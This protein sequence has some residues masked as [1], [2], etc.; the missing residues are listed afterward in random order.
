MIFYFS[1]TYNFLPCVFS[2]LIF[3]V[4]ILSHVFGSSWGFFLLNEKEK[5]PKKKKKKLEKFMT[6]K[7]AVTL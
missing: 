6:V 3:E 2:S 1:L 7:S 5:Y 4:P